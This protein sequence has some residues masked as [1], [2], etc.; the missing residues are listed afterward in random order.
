MAWVRCCGGSKNAP[1]IVSK[2]NGWGYKGDRGYVTLNFDVT[3]GKHYK[4]Y[5]GAVSGSG[6][7]YGGSANW[8]SGQD[9]NDNGNATIIT[10]SSA[11]GYIGTYGSNQHGYATQI[12]SDIVATRTGT[13]TIRAYL[14]GD[15]GHT[16]GGGV[17]GTLVEV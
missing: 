16:C 8:G 6:S 11:G 12:V 5:W 3:A 2:S 1:T 17:Y 15:T 14:M 10:D 7:P 9:I 4:L 13:I